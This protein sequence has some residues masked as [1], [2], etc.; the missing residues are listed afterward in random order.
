[1]FDAVT[2]GA[3]VGAAKGSIN[4]E[5]GTPG[6]LAELDNAGKVPSSQ[7]PS[8]VDDV[9]EGYYKTADGKFYADN[10]YTTEI[11]GETGK[12]YVSVDTGKCYRWSGSVYIVIA[13]P[14]AV[15]SDWAQY[16]SSEM[17]F[18]KNKPPIQNGH[19]TGG[20]L[21]GGT[22]AYATYSNS[23]AYGNGANAIADYAVAIGQSLNAAHA[24]EIAFGKFK[25]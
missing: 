23:I 18:I 17:D 3:A 20:N 22:N 6:G 21:E 8:Y 25:N 14:D 7:L 16:N 15:Q 2:Y 24:H 13:N 19:G 10:A 11:T 9:I 4:A 5:K 1:M 12:I